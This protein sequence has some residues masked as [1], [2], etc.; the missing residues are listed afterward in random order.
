[1]KEWENCHRQPETAEE[2]F[3]KRHAQLRNVI[4]RCFGVI[5]QRFPILKSMPPFPIPT[6]VNVVKCCFMLHNFILKNMKYRDCYDIYNPN[7]SGNNNRMDNEPI[8]DGPERTRHKRWRDRI[9]AQMWTY[10][11][12]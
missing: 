9:A 10:F 6:Q 7:E 11:T 2:L 12:H 8:D 4:E 3:N 5:K 1:L